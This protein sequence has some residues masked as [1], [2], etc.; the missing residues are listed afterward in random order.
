LAA[1]I[2]LATL[3]GCSGP[4][5]SPSPA[6]IPTATSVPA[7]TA[8]FRPAVPPTAT[9]AAQPGIP[10]GAQAAAVATVD[11]SAVDPADIEAAF[12]SNIDDL[13]AEANDLA[14]TPCD[15]LAAVTRSNPNLIASIRGFAATLKR[16]GGSQPVLDTDA[17]KSAFADLDKSMGELEGALGLCGIAQP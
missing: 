10:S 1:V 15:E 12:L 13:I 14:V 3:V 8:T 9:P 16:A 7:P 11:P 17:V 5:P 6:Q 2:V 4:Q